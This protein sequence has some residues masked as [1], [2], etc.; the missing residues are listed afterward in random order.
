MPELLETRS[1]MMDAADE[2][3]LAHQDEV[4]EHLQEL[5]AQIDKLSPMFDI[6]EE[7]Q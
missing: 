1:L 7:S 2:R 3:M 6:T 5:R 4:K